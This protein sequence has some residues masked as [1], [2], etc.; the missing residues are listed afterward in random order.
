MGFD[1]VIIIN[2]TLTKFIMGRKNKAQS[3]PATNLLEKV[4]TAEEKQ[5]G[6]EETTIDDEEDLAIQV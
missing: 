6:Q 1:C 3:T 2:T 5:W 4:E